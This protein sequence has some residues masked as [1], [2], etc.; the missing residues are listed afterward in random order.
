MTTPRG[1][2]ERHTTAV[3]IHIQITWRCVYAPESWV[4]K[5]NERK[6]SET[7]RATSLLID[8]TTYRQWT[9]PLKLLPLPLHHDADDEDG[10]KTK[11]PIWALSIQAIIFKKNCTSRTIWWIRV[12]PQL[13]YQNYSHI[14]LCRHWTVNRYGIYIFTRIIVKQPIGPTGLAIGINGLR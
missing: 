6:K 1:G 5:L 2:W 7:V 13:K 10:R 12:R 11:Y 3:W 9:R 14:R 8:V 4:N